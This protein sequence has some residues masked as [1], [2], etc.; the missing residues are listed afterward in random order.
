MTRSLLAVGLAVLLSTD[1]SPLDVARVLANRYPQ[2]AVMS[3]IP[4]LAWSS[5]MRLSSMTGE[6]KW[7]LRA[8]AQMR[9]FAAGQTPS[10]Q[11]G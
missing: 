8:R 10:M 5:A 11:G 6:Q 3:Y 1:R 4:A 2:D 9:P 7:G